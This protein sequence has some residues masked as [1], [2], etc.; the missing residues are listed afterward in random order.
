MPKPKYVHNS[1]RKHITIGHEG[2]LRH[3]WFGY[4]DVI[5]PGH[6]PITRFQQV[7]AAKSNGAMV[8]DVDIDCDEF[9]SPT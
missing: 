1:K 6:R 2:S 8:P 9:T 3:E 4:N 5:Q 7:E